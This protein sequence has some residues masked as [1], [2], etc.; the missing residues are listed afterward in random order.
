MKTLLLLRHAKSS[1]ATPGQDD[2]DR[3]LNPRGRAAATAMGDWIRAQGLAPD[4]ALVSDAAR[5]V[6]TW[7][8]L[9]MHGVQAQI[10]PALYHAM[11]DTLLN[12]LRQASAARVLMLGHNPG[13]GA[14]AAQL[15]SRAPDHARFAD[16]PTAALLVARFDIDTWQ[17]LHWGSGQ[18]MA[19]VTP[20]DIA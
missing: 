2:H 5:T 14:F 15:L 20:K 3:P 12:A 6:E 13:I 18:A 19:F 4:A 10:L 8:R 7:Q 11:P 16:Y 17:D 9:E 1:W